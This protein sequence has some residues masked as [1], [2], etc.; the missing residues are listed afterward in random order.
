MI[1][2]LSPS[3]LFNILMRGSIIKTNSSGEKASPWMIPL[4]RRTSLTSLFRP[5]READ[6][7]P[8][9]HLDDQDL[10]SRWEAIDVQELLQEGVVHIVVGLLEIIVQLHDFLLVFPLHRVRCH[11]LNHCLLATLRGSDA[12]LLTIQDAPL[13]SHKSHLRIRLWM[14]RVTI[15]VMVG[16]QVMGR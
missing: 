10:D 4:V 6:P 9:H 5:E 8:R 14:A 16:R 11:V 2:A 13:N 12:S 3:C 7:P 1:S 15:F